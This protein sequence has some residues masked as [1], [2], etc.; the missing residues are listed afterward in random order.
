[1]RTVLHVLILCGLT[2]IVFFLAEKTLCELIAPCD[3]RIGE[4]REFCEDVKP[5][6]EYKIVP[7]LDPFG[8][9]IVYPEIECLVVSEETVKGGDAVNTRRKEKVGYIITYFLML[10]ILHCFNKE[11]NPLIPTP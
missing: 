1:M 7:I 4:V 9:S 6:V 3:N 2:E 10:K 5:E 8:P 11:R